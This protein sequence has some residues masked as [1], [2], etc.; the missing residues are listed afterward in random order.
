MRKISKETKMW[1]EFKLDGIILASKSLKGGMS[2]ELSLLEIETRNGVEEVVLREYTDKEWLEMEPDIALQEA[3][4]L[5]QA[6]M[7]SVTTPILIAFDYN[8]ENTTWPSLL[9]TK[10][11]GQVSLKRETNQNYI[12]Q[13]AQ[14]LVKIHQS[15]NPEVT[16]QYFR[17]FDPVQPV[18]AD[19]SSKPENWKQAFRY[20]KTAQ[21]PPYDPTFIHRD[22]HPTNV[23]FENERVSAVVDWTDAC[24]GPK[25]MDIAH[26]RWNLAMIYGQETADSFLNAYLKHDSQMMYHPYW[27]LE[28][29]GNVFTEELP[30]IYGGWSALGISHLTTES[31]INRMDGFVEQALT[32]IKSDA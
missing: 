17:Y 18:K 5:K 24:I 13:L 15:E 6:E 30:Q 32:A 16:H 4:N 26:C 7:L 19:W 3:K 25:Q 8:G 20:L 12:D 10:V 1:V 14:T 23:L 11:E 9:M 22:Y 28:A 2:S 27:D 31:M 21:K 29:S